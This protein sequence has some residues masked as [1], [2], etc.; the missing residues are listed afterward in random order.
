[1]LL[2][3]LTLVEFLYWKDVPKNDYDALK[4]H[5]PHETYV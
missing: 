5:T 2:D 1:M 3:A 4:Q